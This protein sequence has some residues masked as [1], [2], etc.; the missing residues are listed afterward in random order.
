[1]R[2]NH[3]H[4][5]QL[6]LQLALP[7]RGDPRVTIYFSQLRKNKEKNQFGI[8]FGNQYDNVVA[9]FY[10]TNI[11][12]L[13]PG[14]IKLRVNLLDGNIIT[15]LVALKKQTQRSAEIS[16]LLKWVTIQLT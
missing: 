7:P 3:V 10:Y 8:Q 5:R 2:L 9:K 4:H 12:T 16:L 11:V 1:M 15:F 13:M 14:E 6:Q